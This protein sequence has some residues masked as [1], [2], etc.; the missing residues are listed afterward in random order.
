MK[1]IFLPPFQINAE[2]TIKASETNEYQ[3]DKVMIGIDLLHKANLSG[4]SIKIGILDT[5]LREKGHDDFNYDNVIDAKS[6]T[7]DGVIDGN[8]HGTW[9]N[10]AIGAKLN[11]TGV[12]GG[13]YNAEIYVAKVLEN[14]GNGGLV[15]LVQGTQW[16]IEKGCNIINGSLGFGSSKVV[17]QYRHILNEGI[18]SGVIF[19]FASGN[20]GKK[21][22]VDFPA[23][24][25][26]VFSVGAIDSAGRIAS[27]SNKGQELDVVAP[28]VNVLGIS[29]SNTGF[30]SM[31]GTSQASPLVTSFIACYM[32]HYKSINNKFPSFDELYLDITKNNTKD[33]GNTGLDPA[34]GYGMVYPFFLN[35]PVEPIV[36]PGLDL[37]RA[38]EMVYDDLKNEICRAIYK[39]IT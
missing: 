12:V 7:K 18:K 16:L 1:E 9:V 23:L 11:N 8:G 29:H 26:K 14:S 31:S 21:N 20:G 36:C 3:W 28:G 15:P 13:A 37:S 6:F 17:E 32:E 25:D 2:Y 34:Y 27:F 22:E 4:K 38:K 5:G 39:I 19:V 35:K 33:L 30:I 24:I 10:G